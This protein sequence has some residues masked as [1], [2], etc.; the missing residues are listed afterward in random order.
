MSILSFQPTGSNL[1]P[2]DKIWVG[3]WWMAYLV[4]TGLFAFICVP[5]LGFPQ[6]FQSTKNIRA[7]KKERGDS[8]E[9]NTKL[10][11][12]LKSLYP[13]SV[14][15]LQNKSYMFLTLAIT[16][17]GLVIGGFSTFI[18]KFFESQFF[19]PASD[20]ALYAGVIFVPGVGGG[21]LLG[22]YLLKR[23]KWNCQETLKILILFSALAL[24]ASTSIFAGCGSKNITGLNVPYPGE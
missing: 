22:G 2:D 7:V 12:S 6:E 21:I 16:T 19:I 17:E 13:A 15:L 4:G 11:I 10:D 20:A 1:T 24:I 3:A 14:A 18:P 8:I 23:F 5:L 9:D